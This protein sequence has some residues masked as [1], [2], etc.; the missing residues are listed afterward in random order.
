LAGLVTI[1]AGFTGSVITTLQSL[2]TTASGAVSTNAAN[3]DNLDVAGQTGARTA[4]VGSFSSG[5]LVLSN[6]DS[7]NASTAGSAN[8]S[9]NV[10]TGYNTL[11]V[12]APGTETVSGNGA[13]NFLGVFGGN[14]SVAFNT[15]GGNGS[16]Y[17]GGQGDYSVLIGNAWT[18][19]GAPSGGHTVA[20]LAAN[21]SISVAGAGA[22]LQS[23]VVSAD[24]TNVSISAA[25]PN[26][27]VVV[28]GGTSFVSMSGGGNALINGGSATVSAIAG[29]RGV[30]AF[31]DTNGGQLD[32]INNST[33][34]ASVFGAVGGAVG[35]NATIFGGVGGGYFQGGP[36]GNNSLV[37]G[38]GSV[39]LIGGGNNNYLQAGGANNAFFAQ[40][41]ATTMVGATG[42]GANQFSGGTGSLLVS[43]S[44]SG[45]QNFFVGSSGQEILTG[46]TVS[47]AVNSYYFL[48]D[49]T[50]G[51]SD[52]IQ[53]FRLGTDHVYIN[54]FGNASAE[55]VTIAQV[56]SVRASASHPSG[57]VLV[58][59]SNNTTIELFGV[60]ASSIQSDVGG[61]S[62]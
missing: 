23:N 49:S 36:G 40:G 6:A 24:A 29:N 18:Y 55:G 46:S 48:Q 60:N 3:F 42:S 25:G 10:P 19:D 34:A 28:Y 9:V 39:T 4:T 56:D 58:F 17:A 2:L 41:G 13:S 62:I 16:I 14:S 51:G 11:V 57:G 21:T 27:L 47:G 54:P 33:V 30:V 44:G 8:L 61:T 38:T 35:G 52:L 12:Q 32:F 50:G 7:V 59:L 43:T 26:D 22:G 45:A 5:I 53:N 15:N 1:P 37:G 20:D 31:F